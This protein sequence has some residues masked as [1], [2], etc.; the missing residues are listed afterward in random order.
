MHSVE[1]ILTMLVMFGYVYFFALHIYGIF[2]VYSIDLIM[3][4]SFLFDFLSLGAYN[5]QHSC[6]FMLPIFFFCVEQCSFVEHRN[7]K[8]IY[9]RY[10][11]LFFLVGVD[12]EEVSTF[13]PLELLSFPSDQ[14][15]PAF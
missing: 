7:Y 9:R 14:L 15:M 5:V 10:A 11:S 2:L 12:N 8:I 4:F 6:L 1:V 13:C 3:L